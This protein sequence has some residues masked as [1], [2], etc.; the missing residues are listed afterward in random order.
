VIVVLWSRRAVESRWVR[1]EATFADRAGR[2]LPVMLEP[3]DRPIQFELTHTLDL[4]GWSGDVTDPRWRALIEGIRRLIDKQSPQSS[5]RVAAPPPSAVVADAAW[6]RGRTVFVTATVVAVVA[7]GAWWIADHRAGSSSDAA[8]SP[9]TL[10]PAAEVSLAVLP[11]SDL[12]PAGD[13]DYFSDGLTAEIADQLAQ[14][15]ALKLVGRNSSFSF[16]G[17]E[18]DP[19]SA[20]SA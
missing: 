11:F 16:K 14:I 17:K 18:D 3:C 12:S 1:S 2:L 8:T 19:R 6:R 20:D 9:S 5:D 15:P 7:V 4:A 10:A 13:Q